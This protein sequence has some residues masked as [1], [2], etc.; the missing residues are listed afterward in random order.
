MSVLRIKKGMKFVYGPTYLQ[1][2]HILD[3]A[4]PKVRDMK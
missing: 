4:N 2:F 3:G 1:K